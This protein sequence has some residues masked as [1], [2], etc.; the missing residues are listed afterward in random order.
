VPYGLFSPGFLPDRDSLLL[1]V[2]RKRLKKLSL[3][4]GYYRFSGR[5][6]AA[7][8]LANPVNQLEKNGTVLLNSVGLA[9]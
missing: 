2:R 1:L 3:S 4:S 9:Q 7:V 5:P 6:L 8:V